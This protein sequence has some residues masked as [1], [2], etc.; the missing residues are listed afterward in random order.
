MKQIKITQKKSLIG[1]IGKHR[2]TA[3]ALGL[4]KINHSVIKDDTPEI[5]GMVAS[6]RYL[7][8]VEEV[9]GKK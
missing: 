9:K 2:R 6:I 4:K 8:E 3:R 7:L 1:R 5:R